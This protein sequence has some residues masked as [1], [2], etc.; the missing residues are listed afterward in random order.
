M[1]G[2]AVLVQ[3]VREMRRVPDHDVLVEDA[4]PVDKGAQVGWSILLWL[5][6][7]A[8]GGGSPIVDLSLIEAQD[9][10]VPWRES[11][12]GAVVRA[13]DQVVCVAGLPVPD[14]PPPVQV[15]PSQASG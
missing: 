12:R 4:L 7:L 9:P 3:I 2:I 10:E 6:C 1:T 11:V 14:L 8:R 13:G 5:S 15:A